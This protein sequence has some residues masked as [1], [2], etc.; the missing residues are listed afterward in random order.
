MSNF[1]EDVTGDLNN[2]EEKVLGPQY[3]YAK[4]IKNPSEMNMSSKGTISQ[5]G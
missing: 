2:I 3:N 1:F 5:A 4:N